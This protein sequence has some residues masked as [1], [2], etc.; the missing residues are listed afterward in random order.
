M[1]AAD[2]G[3][4]IA[5]RRKEL[6]MTQIELAQKLYVTNKAVSKWENGMNFPELSLMEPLASALGISVVELLGLEEKTVEEA[7]LETADISTMEKQR[8]QKK[9]RGD[10]FGTIFFGIIILIAAF[11]VSESVHPVSDVR[12]IVWLMQ[13]AAIAIVGGGIRLA[14]RLSLINKVVLSEKT[15][16]VVRKTGQ[17]IAIILVCCLLAMVVCATIIAALLGVFSM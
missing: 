7:V 9:M 17:T 15:V 11:Y 3:A 5:E 14:I 6:G 1:N 4:K 13:I 16:R 10:I 8:Q 12:S 2:V